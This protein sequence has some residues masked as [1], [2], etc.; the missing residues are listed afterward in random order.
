MTK[1]FKVLTTVTDT[2]WIIR[3]SPE[4]L[5]IWIPEE[6]EWWGIQQGYPLSNAYPAERRHSIGKAFSLDWTLQLPISEEE[7]AIELF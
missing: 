4:G 2:P 3:T 7:V 5:Y 1:Y 6:E